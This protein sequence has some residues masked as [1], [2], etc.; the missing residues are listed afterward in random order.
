MQP[1]SLSAC[2]VAFALGAFSLSPLKLELFAQF[3]GCLGR[4]KSEQS[5]SHPIGQEG[6]CNRHENRQSGAQPDT[7]QIHPGEPVLQVIGEAAKPND[8]VGEHE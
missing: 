7:R 5:M 2:V 3:P 6:P 1:I 4:I 8:E